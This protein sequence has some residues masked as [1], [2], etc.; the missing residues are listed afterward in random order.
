MGDFRELVLS[1]QYSGL[2]HNECLLSL[3]VDCIEGSL[4]SL[5]SFLFMCQFKGP[6]FVVPRQP[7]EKSVTNNSRIDN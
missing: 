6:I 2:S 4:C 1:K 3:F 7:E 5:F